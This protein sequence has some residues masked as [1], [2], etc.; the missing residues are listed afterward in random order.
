MQRIDF[1]RFIQMQVNVKND[2]FHMWGYFQYQTGTAQISVR[3][4]W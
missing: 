4:Y 2:S 3:K 1:S